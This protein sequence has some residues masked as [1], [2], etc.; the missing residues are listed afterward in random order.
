V[1]GCPIRTDAKTLEAFIRSA[2]GREGEPS[3]PTS[4][5]GIGGFG[6]S[7]EHEAVKHSVSEFVRAMGIR[8][9]SRAS[10]FPAEARVPRRLP[11]HGREAPPAVRRR[12]RRKVQH[13]GQGHPRPDARGCRRDGWAA[14]P[15]PRP[16]SVTRQLTV[17]RGWKVH[18]RLP[19]RLQVQLLVFP[20]IKLSCR[21]DVIG[22]GEKQF[23]FC[24]DQVIVRIVSVRTRP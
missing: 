18:R 2:N 16:D 14:A 12:V 23:P 11:S 22:P 19:A 21:G 13:P 6:E 8:K 24:A 10:S 1:S 9:G 15:L 5:E 7:Y 20:T 4:T 17:R 3:K